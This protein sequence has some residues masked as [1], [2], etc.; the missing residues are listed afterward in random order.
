MFSYFCLRCPDHIFKE[1]KQTSSR[2]IERNGIQAT[3]LCTHKND[4]EEINTIKLKNLKGEARVF[5]SVDSDVSYSDQ[6]DNLL[7]V[8]QR[9]ELKIGAQ[10][11]Y[12]LILSL[13]K[14]MFCHYILTKSF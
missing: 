6:M 7:P 2:A 5:L 14:V 13:D 4:V 8:K 10:V 9:M 1:L 12:F 11:H 3:K